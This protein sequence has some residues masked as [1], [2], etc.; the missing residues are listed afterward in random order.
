MLVVIMYSA[1]LLIMLIIDLGFLTPLMVNDLGDWGLWMAIG[2]NLLI[3][4]PAS[5]FLGVAT[6]KKLRKTKWFRKRNQ[7]MKGV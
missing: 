4:M 5:W 7:K 1:F 3:V 6:L 2:F